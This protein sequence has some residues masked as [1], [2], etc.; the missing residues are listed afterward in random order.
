M[1]ATTYE[2]LRLNQTNRYAGYQ[3]SCRIRVDGMESFEAFRY[4]ILTIYEWIRKKVP[5]E[6]RNAPELQLPEPGKYAETE[7]E[8]FVPYH[9][10][11][12]YAMDITPLL[13]E[14]IWALRIKEPDAGTTDREAVP[15]RFFTT[16]VGLR[17]NERG[18]TELGIRIDVTD[19][20][21]VEKELE[22][23]FRPNFVRILFEQPSV[24]VE[25]VEE[26][27]YD[28]AVRI[29]TEEDYRRL[30][31]MLDSEDNQLP[32]AV[33]TYA[34]PAGGSAGGMSMEEFVKSGMADLDRP[35]L[36]PL[37]RP[38]AGKESR[39]EL[40]YDANAFCGKAFGYAVTYVLADAFTDRFRNR[41][42]KDFRNG[43]I[44]LCGA[45]K[46]RGGVSV[47]GC[48]ED[49]G[50]EREKAFKAAVLAARQYSKH[51]ATYS[52][53]S[54]MFE[55]EARKTRQ[56]REFR[57]IIDG[58]Y[59]DKEKYDKLVDMVRDLNEVINGKDEKIGR[60]SKQC[61]E[62]FD[63][64]RAFMAKENDAL[65]TEND[66]L[67]ERLASCQTRIGQMEGAYQQARE[68]LDVLER[69][70]SVDSLPENN[71]DVVRYFKTVY[72]DRLGF[73][74]RGEETA[75][76][77]GYKPRSLWKIL[78]TVSNQLTDAFRNTPENLTEER[79]K[80]ETGFDVS[81]RE[82]PMTREK[83]EFMRLR[84]DVYNG[85]DISVEPHI[86][87][88][89]GREEPDDQRLHFCYDTE[90][91]KVIIGYL[92]YHLD[93]AATQYVR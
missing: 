18:Y 44:L 49:S 77:C 26:L 80:Q 47:F 91:R 78:Y 35:F 83:R 48:A 74:E 89:S 16:R 88:K 50:K 73:T 59:E 86:K 15:G 85:K 76:N 19:P 75:S 3:F 69:I 67:R 87:L 90:T 31:Y 57:T 58:R 1:S 38:A 20:A 12:G 4:L 10:S 17:L 5:E 36:N 24:H 29:E 60:L 41:I 54:V 79:I 2:P 63:R 53:G 51:K 21:S 82:G 37:F 62:E 33:F 66:E 70:Q 34:R 64:G 68:Q 6:D 52:F 71:A 7:A 92:G 84:E 46:F 42:R 72:P 27:R 13:Y 81:F 56:L 32:L 43:D 28:K 8:D 93:S 65:Q 45:K 11:I 61:E 39:P 9:F 25:Q 40:L 22:Y 23:A 55:A 14:G 30:L